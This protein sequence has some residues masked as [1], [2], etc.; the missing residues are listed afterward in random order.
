[1]L[2]SKWLHKQTLGQ[3][4]QRAERR[5]V[6]GL[7]AYHR[8][9][10][11]L[12]KVSIKDIS[13]SGLYL[14]TSE[15]WMPGELVTLTLQREG[16][17][18]RDLEKR[19]A[20][21]ARS[22]WW[23]DDG[24]GLDFILNEDIGF[25]LWEGPLNATAGEPE[26]EDIIREFRIAEALTFLGKLCP[27]KIKELTYLFRKE[28]SP[29][30]VMTAAE[31]SLEAG[32]T[33]TFRPDADQLRVHPDVMMRLM[34]FGS[35]AEDERLRRFWSGLLIASCTIGE[36]NATDANLAMIDPLSQLSV[37]HVLILTAACTRATLSL[38]PDGSV[39]AEQCT[40]P[41]ELITQIT[42][43]RDVTK[44]DRD[45][46]HLYLQGFLDQRK[47][48]LALLPVDEANLTPTSLGLEF[49]ARCK[50][51]T[52]PIKEFYG[53]PLAPE[54]ASAEPET[55]SPDVQESAPPAGS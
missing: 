38:A 22:V 2:L 1:M 26:P 25:D 31:I 33:L 44:N 27:S 51:H 43:T 30:R 10:M 37:K 19:A 28:F 12:N 49:Y 18:E 53:L 21:Q 7:V 52:G 13:S 16:P 23:G 3:T 15:R 29:S 48:A 8:T 32:R 5:P 47:R 54:L 6:N 35:W 41:M 45:L 9:G 42:G 4:Q 46:G 36:E 17:P 40:S 20:V 24:I 11:V 34:E 14:L 39:V 55:S 50:G